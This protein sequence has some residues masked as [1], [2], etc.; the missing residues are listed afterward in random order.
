MS[1]VIAKQ[2]IEA[3]ADLHKKSG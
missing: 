3:Y 1:G 2:Y